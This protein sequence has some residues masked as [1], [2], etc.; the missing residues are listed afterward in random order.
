[1]R[2]LEY[3]FYQKGS[4]GRQKPFS[5]LSEG[6]G[7]AFTINTE[8]GE[9]P[10]IPHLHTSVPLPCLVVTGAGIDLSIWSS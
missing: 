3:H 5:W 1:V 6:V 10:C 9:K 8:A 7:G 2:F 4:G